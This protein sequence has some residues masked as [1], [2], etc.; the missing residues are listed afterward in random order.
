MESRDGEFGD[1]EEASV[2]CDCANDNEGAG[3][4]GKFFAV[5]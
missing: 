5:A 2:V 3:C 1:F 4:R